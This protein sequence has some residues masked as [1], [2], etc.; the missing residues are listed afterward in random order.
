MLLPHGQVEFTRGFGII[1]MVINSFLHL[2]LKI[3]FIILL[4]TEVY[5]VHYME[6]TN[7]RPS[8]DGQ[9]VGVY[10]DYNTAQKAAIRFLTAKGRMFYDI[11][12]YLLI[13][14][15][16]CIESYPVLNSF[17]NDMFSIPNFRERYTCTS[18]ST[19]MEEF[20]EDF[21]NLKDPFRYISPRSNWDY[22]I[23][24]CKIE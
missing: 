6:Q 4:M 19:F 1:R 23:E 7:G 22:H 13:N 11:W 21:V 10:N 17:Y 5:V 16:P 15:I 14:G 3:E 9:I 2:N 8:F 18:E 20:L 24:K 12:D